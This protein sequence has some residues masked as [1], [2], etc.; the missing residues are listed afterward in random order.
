V[1]TFKKLFFTRKKV[2]QCGFNQHV[3]TPSHPCT[4]QVITVLFCVV[5]CELGFVFIES[6]IPLALWVGLVHL[7]FCSVLV[8]LVLFLLQIC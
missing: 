1:F 4:G 8:F 6:V 7:F 2:V 5:I 3:I